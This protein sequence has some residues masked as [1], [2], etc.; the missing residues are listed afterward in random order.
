MGPRRQL[1]LAALVGVVAAVVALA[2]AEVIALLFVIPAASPLV[3]VGSFVIDIV[4]PWVKDAAIALFG[5]GDKAALLLGLGLL[6]TILAAAIGALQYRL[7]PAGVIGLTAVGLVALI[8]AGTRAEATAVWALPTII[9]FLL[10]AVVLILGVRRLRQW[11]QSTPPASRASALSRRG[12]IGFLGATAGAALVAGLAARAVNATTGA[13]NTVREA[14]T[15]PKPAVPASPVPTDA[16]LDIPGLSS[17]FTSNAEFYRIDTAIIV[18][19]IEASEW[20]LRVVGMVENELEITLDELLALPLIETDVTLTCVSNE[21]GGGLIGNARWMGYP[22]REL[23][24]RAKPKTGADMVLSRSVDGFTAGTPLGV[25]QDATRDSILAVSM[26]GEPLPLEHGFPVRMVV[27]GLYGYVSA[28][29]WVT[30]L[31]LTRFADE[32]AYW[33]DRGWSALGPIK[34]SSRIDV[35]SYTASVPL[36]PMPIAGVAWAQHTGIESVEIRVDKGAWMPTTLATAVS[37][38]TWVQW[39]TQWTPAEPK[40]YLIEVRATDKNG[41]VQ[42]GDRVQPP[43][44]GSEGWH[45]ITV[46]VHA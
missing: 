25:L 9:G 30:E 18:P 14:L 4:P 12:F 40:V 24:A 37:D 11:M 8:A 36:E 34:L 26:N 29:K 23:L 31:K 15:L 42:S 1:S 27:P 3:A 43:P 41:K 13:V 10:G 33:T 2:A 21:V 39:S 35:P 46:E 6:V 45:A 5:T 7:P 19:R 20:R 22:I 38:D 44:N 17:L 16:E 28:T 32:T